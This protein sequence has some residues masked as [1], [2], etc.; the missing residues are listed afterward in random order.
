MAK[1]I[2]QAQMNPNLSRLIDLNSYDPAGYTEFKGDAVMT[3]LYNIAAEFIKNASNNLEQSDRI[4]TGN[5]LDSISPSEIT[6]MGKTYSI[7]INVNDYYKFIDKGVK[8]WK[9]GSPSDSPYAFKQ[10][11][12]RGEAP[13]NSKMVSAIRQWLIKEVLKSTT[14]TGRSI[15]RRESRRQSVT[16]AST[17]AAIVISQNIKRKGL[18]KTNFWT[19]AEQQTKNYA[20][21]EIGIA[22]QIDIINSL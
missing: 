12:K 20:E 7:Q 16:D 5:L 2:T 21:N 1:S 13:K 17:R 6:I 10:P 14:S 11:G 8:G 15:T 3:A 9:S 18:I 22:L 4:S 19:K